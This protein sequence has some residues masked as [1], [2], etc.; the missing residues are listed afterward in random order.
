M[1]LQTPPEIA[2]GGYWYVLPRDL[3]NSDPTVIPGVR[4][5]AYHGN[6]LAA[7]RTPDAVS[8]I[9]SGGGVTAVLAEAVANGSLSVRT[10]KP[11]G[12]IGGR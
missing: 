7:V 10:G 6:T 1:N 2:D 4:W 11:F 3:V 12:R 5:C 9:N 8:G